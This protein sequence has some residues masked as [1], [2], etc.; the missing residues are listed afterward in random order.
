MNGKEAK[1]EALS[2]LLNG[3][4]GTLDALCDVLECEISEA[5][6]ELEAEDEPM[7][8]WRI[9]GRIMGMR[10]LLAAIRPRFAA[11]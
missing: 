3:S 7:E 4:R 2:K 1:R 9:Q 10:D 11:R 6:G 5:Q 8:L